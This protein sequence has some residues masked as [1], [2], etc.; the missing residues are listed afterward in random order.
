M[1]VFSALVLYFG[2]GPM[3]AF[4]VSDL[5]V[6]VV[7]LTESVALGGKAELMVETEA[8]ALCVG[9]AWNEEKPV[10][11][12][13]LSAQSVDSNGHAAWTWQVPKAGPPGRWSIDLQCATTT[14]KERLSL[15]FV[16]Q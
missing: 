14:K 1:H 15:D 7:T 10:Q 6:K 2:V 11:R 16:A 3:R 9:K 13:G 8:G 12:V 5:T 4:G